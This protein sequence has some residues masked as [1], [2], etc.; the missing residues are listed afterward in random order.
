MSK[1]KTTKV[2]VTELLVWLAALFCGTCCSVLN[3]QML[4]VRAENMK[5]EMTTF[6]CPLFQTFAMF[7]GMAI[8]VPCHFLVKHFG[9]SFPGY[10]PK[11]PTKT[12]MPMWMYFYLITPACFDLTATFLS[13]CGLNYVNVS[14][15]QMLRGAAIVFVAILKQFFLND[16]LNNY[17]WIGIFWNVVAILLVGGV[18]M[19]TPQG[20]SGSDDAASQ[21]DD[22]GLGIALI[23]LSALVGAFQYA[24]EERAMKM[25]IAAPPLFLIGMEG[26]W[27]CVVCIFFMY[28]VAYL[29]P[30][31]DLGSFENPWNTYYMLSH[32]GLLFTIFVFFFLSVFGYNLFGILVTFMLHSVWRAILDNF[33]PITVWASSLAIY[34][35]ISTSFGEMWTSASWIQVVGLIVLLY[36]TAIYN[37]PNAGS[38]KLTGQWYNCGIDLTD[39]YPDSDD[40]FM[41]E[42]TE[43]NIQS[44]PSPIIHS[45]YLRTTPK[46][47]SRGNSINQT[48]RG[49]ARLMEMQAGRNNAA[50]NYSALNEN[51]QEFNALKKTMSLGL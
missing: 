7:I 39:E 51:D 28:P 26:F 17:Q 37:A 12:D 33:R 23:L 44:L 42:D 22:P 47:R 8:G 41:D 11:D 1:P 24:F 38:I 13:M 18:A 50:A 5:G 30:G 6:A 3:K 27:G 10:N 14:I 25:E 29:T 43:I 49:Q 34:Y 46:Q 48:P 19:V 4:L 21:N 20:A 31:N 9:I 45:P 16:P 32:N 35:L 15:Y 40:D 36:G 2:G